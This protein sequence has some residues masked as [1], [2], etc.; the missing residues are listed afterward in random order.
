MAGR[1]GSRSELRVSTGM[2]LRWSGRSLAVDNSLYFFCYFP[3]ERFD[4]LT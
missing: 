1:D 4:L 3:A 2:N